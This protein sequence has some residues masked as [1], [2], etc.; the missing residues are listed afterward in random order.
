MKDWIKGGLIGFGSG[1]ILIGLCYLLVLLGINQ[2]SGFLI[3]FVGLLAIP[4][5]FLFLIISLIFGIDI[6]SL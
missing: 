6:N 5:G 3:M 4:V 2:L 1:I